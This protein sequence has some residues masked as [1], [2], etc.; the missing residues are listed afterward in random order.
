MTITGISLLLLF[1][2]AAAIAV[3]MVGLSL[4]IRRERRTESHATPYECGLDPQGQPRHRL[5]IQ[6][7]LIAVIFIIFD[8]EVVF[9]YPWAVVFRDFVSRGMG[10]LM[11]IEMGIFVGVLLLGFVYIWGRGSLEWEE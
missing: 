3:G 6:F 9:L 10:P 4:L 1:T 5:H 7:F 8:V 11:L 2:V